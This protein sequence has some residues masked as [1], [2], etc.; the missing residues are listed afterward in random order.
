MHWRRER[1]ARSPSG[2]CLTA[3]PQASLMGGCVTAPAETPRVRNATAQTRLLPA[4]LCSGAWAG[5]RDEFSPRLGAGMLWGWEQ[6]CC[7]AGSR[8]ARLQG[9]VN[10]PCAWWP[11]AQ[12]ISPLTPLAP[13]GFHCSSSLEPCRVGAADQGLLPRRHTVPPPQLRWQDGERGAP[14]CPQLLPT[15]EPPR[16]PTWWLRLQGCPVTTDQA[17]R[18]L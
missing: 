5:Q 7:R 12:H 3:A 4:L 9:W 13:M 2:M 6:G 17:Q 1:G 8:T 10:H 16:P 18:R 11:L 14:A 15:P